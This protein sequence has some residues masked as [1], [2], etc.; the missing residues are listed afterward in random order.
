MK[1]PLSWKKGENLVITSL[2]FEI[3]AASEDM[4]MLLGVIGTLLSMNVMSYNK[5][6]ETK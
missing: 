3:Q 1:K 2:G 4:S 6:L 5:Y